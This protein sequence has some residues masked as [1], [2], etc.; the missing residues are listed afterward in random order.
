MLAP[1]GDCSK[2]I[3][4]ALRLAVISGASAGIQP[5]I[6]DLV[7]RLGNQLHKHAKRGRHQHRAARQ[8]RLLLEGQAE[9]ELPG[10]LRHLR[11]CEIAV[12]C[13]SASLPQNCMP[14]ICW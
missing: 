7:L 11:P 5:G 3:F 6:Q 14:A 1:S 8:Q 9:D 2:G 10:L 12:H 4:L 13:R